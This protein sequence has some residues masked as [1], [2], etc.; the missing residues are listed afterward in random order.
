MNDTTPYRPSRG[1]RWS[2]IAFIVCGVAI[3]VVTA[4]L[5]IGRIIEILGPGPTAVS[6]EFADFSAALSYGDS[7]G[8][9][10]VAV[11]TG[12]IMATD[13]PLASTVAGVLG[14]ILAVLLTAAVVM[15]LIALSVSLLRGTIFSKRN[16][17]LVTTAGMIGLIGAGAAKLF[18]VMLANGA[19]ASATNREY[20]GFATSIAPGSF[21]MAAFIIALVC[22]VF[23]IGE[24]MQRDQEGLV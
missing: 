15:C 4:A 18:D 12:T 24:R 10:P 16:T 7:G 6:V 17:W 14:A 1:D 20:Q 21:I 22:T 13:L 19:I 23:T 3:V 2:L 11:D 9:L 8:T 5:A